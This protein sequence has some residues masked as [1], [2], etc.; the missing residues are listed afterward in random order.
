MAISTLATAGVAGAQ[1]MPVPTQVH[2]EFAGPYVGI[3]LGENWSNAKGV[4][5]TATRARTFFGAMAGYGFDVGPF[6]LG[7]EVFADLHNGSTTGRDAGVDARIGL[8]INRIMPYARIGFTGISPDTRFHGGLG[9]E[10]AVSEDVHVGLEWAAD[11]SHTNGTKRN[12]NSLT[13]GLQYYFQ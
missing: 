2:S 13:V 9:V 12:N 4:V 3:K 10:Y 8:P 1:E 7:P 6:V 5:N 11:T